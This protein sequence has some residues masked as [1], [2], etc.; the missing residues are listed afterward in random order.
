MSE[1]RETL[2]RPELESNA[3]EPNRTFLVEL[4]VPALG[5][6]SSGRDFVE[7]IR[8]DLTNVYRRNPDQFR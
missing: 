2:K 4:R 7:A 6:S 8:M 1:P 5:S 3:S